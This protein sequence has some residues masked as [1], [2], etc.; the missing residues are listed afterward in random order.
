MS[1]IQTLFSSLFLLLNEWKNLISKTKK[2]FIASLLTLTLGAVILCLF[3]IKGV[4]SHTFGDI[5]IVILA[6]LIAILIVTSPQVFKS[7]SGKQP[8]IF[9]RLMAILIFGAP[10][11]ILVF[12]FAIQ[13][14]Q[15]QL[16][17]LIQAIRYSPP[18][19]KPYVN[20]W[21]L[22]LPS[23]IKLSVLIQ[24]ISEERYAL[25][26]PNKSEIISL[27][28]LSRI[29][30]FENDMLTSQKDTDKDTPEF[31]WKIEDKSWSK[32]ILIKAPPVAVVGIDFKGVTLKRRNY[33]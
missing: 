23:G 27:G 25:I 28:M 2:V 5:L 29:Y 32:M 10:L 6:F 18:T 24:Q 13:Y 31:C 8:P 15:P 14:C 4:L 26:S 16:S 9:I 33:K 1:S 17:E 11:I 3:I 30:V 21:E 22:S 19:K 20:Q 7:G 12:A